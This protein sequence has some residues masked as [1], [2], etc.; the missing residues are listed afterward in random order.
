MET[1]MLL[2]NTYVRNALEYGSVIWSPHYVIYI[3]RIEKIQRS[4]TRRLFRKFHFVYEN[5]ENRLIR[6]ELLSLYDRRIASDEMAFYKLYNNILSSNISNSIARKNSYINLRRRTQFYPPFASTNIEYHSAINRMQ[7]KH[8]ELF[9]NIDLDTQS[10]NAF[11][12]YVIH[13]LR[14]GQTLNPY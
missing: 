13:E 1:Y 3:E 12:R 10:I 11:K 7:R 14:S 2:Y 5:Y 4:F 8:D 6:L 9:A